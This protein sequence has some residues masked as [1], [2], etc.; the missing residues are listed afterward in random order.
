LFSVSVIAM[1]KIYP[2]RLPIRTKKKRI[3]YSPCR[4]RGIARLYGDD[5]SA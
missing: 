5:A 2:W 4:H 3:A 1:E